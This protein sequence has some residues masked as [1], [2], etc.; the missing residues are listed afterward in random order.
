MAAWGSD[1]LVVKP[2][3]GLPQP[4]S[5][6]AD[7]FVLMPFKE[8][9]R[10]VYEDHMRNLAMQHK[11]VMARADDLFSAGSLMSDIWNAM[12]AARVI[13]ADCT[14]QNPNVFYEIGMAHTLGKTVI[15]ISQRLDDIPA[16]LRGFKIILYE[17]SLRGWKN[18]RIGCRKLY[19]QNSGS[20]S[21]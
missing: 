12:N 10:P 18:S 11:Y 9:L 6:D 21:L 5:R 1:A 2:L 19:K 20:R 16:D 15:L 7:I 4:S 17:H 13:V 14:G 8:S 3:F